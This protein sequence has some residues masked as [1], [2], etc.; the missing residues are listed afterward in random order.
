MPR[1]LDCCHQPTEIVDGKI[2]ARP[3]PCYFCNTCERAT[4]DC[5]MGKHYCV[6][7]KGSKQDVPTP[8]K[9]ELLELCEYRYIPTP[10]T[11][12]FACMFRLK[13]PFYNIFEIRPFEEMFLA[14]PP[15]R[16]ATPYDF[17]I[18][19]IVQRNHLMNKRQGFTATKVAAIDVESADRAVIE[20]F[21]DTPPIEILDGKVQ[22]FDRVEYHTAENTRY[23]QR[24][25]KRENQQIDH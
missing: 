3:C 9:F 5:K 25:S 12:C 22:A 14:T 17:I 21:M 23:G 16:V 15:S 8:F 4:L 1:W 2:C 10:F 18:I 13:H 19:A 6:R 7:P 11:R 24:D 20:T